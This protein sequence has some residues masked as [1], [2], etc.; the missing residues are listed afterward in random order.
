MKIHKQRQ[1]NR[2]IHINY[3]FKNKR[4]KYKEYIMKIIKT[5]K[6]LLKIIKMIIITKTKIITQEKLLN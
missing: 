1:K 6:I 2:K 4:N 3:T 5:M